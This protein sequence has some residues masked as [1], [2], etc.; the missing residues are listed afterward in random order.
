MFLNGNVTRS[1]PLVTE[2]GTQRR[3]YGPPRSKIRRTERLLTPSTP[4]TSSALAARPAQ[5]RSG[6]LRWPGGF[7]LV[8]LESTPRMRIALTA[9]GFIALLLLSACTAAI[10]TTPYPETDL[11]RA[12]DA[13]N[14]GNGAACITANSLRAQVYPR[15]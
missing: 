10:S 1:R 12:Q 3:G 13:C 6:M 11:G 7:F 9:I 4:L 14:A 8:F 2:S 5:P 15:W